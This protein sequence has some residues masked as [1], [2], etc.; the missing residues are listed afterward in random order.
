MSLKSAFV[1]NAFLRANG[2]SALVN[3]QFGC[4][5][6]GAESFDILPIQVTDDGVKVGQA[7]DWW[8]GGWVGLDSWLDGW[9][10]GWSVD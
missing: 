10:D 4:Y 6:H 9:F 8:V 3:A 2:P 5:K 7:V 1:P